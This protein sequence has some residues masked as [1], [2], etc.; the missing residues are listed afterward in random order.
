MPPHVLYRSWH[1]HFLI[2]VFAA[3]SRDIIFGSSHKVQ[4]DRSLSDI[5]CWRYKKNL[6]GSQ[7]GTWALKIK[8][9]YKRRVLAIQW[10]RVHLVRHS[11]KF[12]GY[13]INQLTYTSYLTD[14]D[15][16]LSQLAWSTWQIYLR[17]KVKSINF[18]LQAYSLAAL[19]GYNE[20]HR[21]Y[22]IRIRMN[23]CTKYNQGA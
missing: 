8:F 6:A 9:C 1:L 17:Q 11:T 23:T 22:L 14:L 7:D 2:V 15:D 10:Y 18:L 19:F 4:I 13:M 20:I 5:W 21:M 16:L 3:L 12:A